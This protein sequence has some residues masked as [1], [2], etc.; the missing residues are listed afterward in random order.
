MKQQLNYGATLKVLMASA[1]ANFTELYDAVAVLQA[2]ANEDIQ[3]AVV[4]DSVTDMVNGLNAGTDGAGN[5]LDLVI[6]DE[7][8]I[9]DDDTPD[10]WVSAV[11]SSSSTGTTPSSWERGINYAF[12]KYV[13]RVSKSR[14]IEL[15][16]YQK[17][18]NIVEALSEN[19]DHTH[20]PSAKAVYDAILAVTNQMNTGFASLNSKIANAGKIQGIKVDGSDSTLDIDESGI[21]T[22]PKQ[23][24]TADDLEANYD[25]TATPT[26][27]LING[28]T[29]NAIKVE[30]TDVTLEVFNSDGEAVITQIIR[31]NDGFI[32]FCFEDNDTDT[33]TI[34]KVGG[35]AVSGGGG[36]NTEAIDNI[37]R[38]ARTAYLYQH[39]IEFQ[40]DGDPTANNGEYSVGL[41]FT[42]N[43][44]DNNASPITDILTWL[45][46]CPFFGDTYF[47]H[48]FVAAGE[49]HLY[50][51]E[52]AGNLISTRII[53]K[54]KIINNTNN[55]YIICIIS[56]L[57][58]E[59]GVFSS[60]SLKEFE[61]TFALNSVAATNGGYN[62]LSIAQHTVLPIQINVPSVG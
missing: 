13:I 20:Y 45:D 27:C 8:Y 5:A 23:T 61:F 60:T 24:V 21:V 19:S 31:P 17:I 32:Y 52:G 9:L 43:Y 33:Y 35:N 2:L 1:N 51:T 56:G 40:E 46:Y 38:A 18:S 53:T 49:L 36:T 16:D 62:R 25:T 15:V 39:S 58:L 26:S 7:I 34:R 29:Y 4:Y 10:F 47:A 14:E 42:I 54:A 55:R 3:K 28:T 44:I 48:T 37:A 11:N 59:D 22:I 50:D 57:Y 6:G 41:N 30:D 12:G